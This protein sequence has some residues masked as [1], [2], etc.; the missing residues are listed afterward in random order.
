MN[1]SH[2]TFSPCSVYRYTL[3]RDLGMQGPQLTAVMLNPSTAEASLAAGALRRQPKAS[4]ATRPTDLAR[5]R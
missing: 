2:A 5:R 3:F 4:S 1:I